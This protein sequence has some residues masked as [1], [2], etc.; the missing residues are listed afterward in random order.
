LLRT[1]KF[2]INIGA[3]PALS[4]KTVN[5]TTDSV[6]KE[7]ITA[8]RYLAGEISPYYFPVKNIGIGVYYFYAYCIEKDL[9][10]NTQLVSIRSNFSNI[11]ISDN[12]F[13]KFAPQIYYLRMALIGLKFESYCLFL[14]FCYKFL[15]YVCYLFYY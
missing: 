15:I 6:S 11:R 13:M 1:D 4:F 10:R 8:D 7:K 9:T 2:Q 3:H 14:L 5:I 12:V